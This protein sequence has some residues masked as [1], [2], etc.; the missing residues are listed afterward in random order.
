MFDFNKT[1]K[2][3]LIRLP[4]L[5][6]YQDIILF[7]ESKNVT[8]ASTTG[9]KIYYNSDYFS[10]ISKDEQLFTLAH[11]FLHIILKHIPRLEG[12][13]IEIWNYAT[14]AVINQMLVKMGFSMPYGVIDCPDAINYSSEEYYE[15][16]KNRPDCEELMDIYRDKS[17]KEESITTH[18]D[19]SKL[20]SE[21]EPEYNDENNSID[22]LPDISEEDIIKR[23]KELVKKEN[24]EFKDSIDKQSGNIAGMQN[25]TITNVGESVPVI[26]WTLFLQKY[27]RK[28][29]SADYNLNIGEFNEEGFYVYPYEVKRGCE[30]EIVIDTSGSV[31][32]GMVRAF[33][34]EC[35]N[36]FKETKIK[37]GCFDTK[38]Y[39][40]HEIQSL[41][42]IDNFVIEGRGGTDFDV[43][44]EAFSKKSNVKIIFTD[45]YSS[46][47]KK[48]IDALWILWSK[49]KLNPPGGKVIYLDPNTLNYESRKVR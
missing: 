17:K 38:F 34:R 24:Q 15:I 28:I 43:A 35:K 23:N 46:E 30:V 31:D 8:T 7:K 21:I 9:T 3:L 49:T 10:S 26:D 16:T 12:K 19:W 20:P 18:S 39:G 32:D 4:I 45:G 1:L 37:I 40:F 14:D 44:V 22:K 13:D 33:L 25:V 47:P 11:E 48:S 5:K 29:I 6:E 41:D 2:K 27:K 42:D 36:I